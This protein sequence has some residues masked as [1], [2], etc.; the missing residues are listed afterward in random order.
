MQCVV[1]KIIWTLCLVVS[2]LSPLSLRHTGPHTKEA[3]RTTADLE[4]ALFVIP[5][6]K[7][8]DVNPH[9][10]ATVSRLEL[11][12]L[13]LITSWV[14][15]LRVSESPGW[16]L[17]IFTG[18]CCVALLAL[19]TRCVCVVHL[20]YRPPWYGPEEADHAEPVEKV[21]QRGDY[22]TYLYYQ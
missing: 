2:H 11:P 21:K 19:C 17:P 13:S 14:D 22:E 1:S 6:R 18:C 8:D 3:S 4:G 10:W 9:T 15:S 16:V 12:D 20:G 5:R 7:M